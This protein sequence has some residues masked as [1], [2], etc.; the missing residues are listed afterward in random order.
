[1]VDITDKVNQFIRDLKSCDYYCRMIIDCNLKL[2]VVAYRLQGVSSPRV[3]DVVYENTAD[4]YSNASKAELMMEE[5]RLIRERQRSYDRI[6]ACAMIDNIKNPHDKNLI[7]D[8]YV[9]K[10]RHIELEKKYNYNRSSI[11][12]RSKAILSD[13]LNVATLFT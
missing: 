3:K 4:P 7:I 2:E 6:M 5:E 10:M 9:I 12:R 13:L 8:L 11:Y 1:M